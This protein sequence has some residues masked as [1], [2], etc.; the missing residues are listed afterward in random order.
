MKAVILAGGLGTRL[1]EETHLRP[2]PMVEVGGMPILWH[3]MKGFASHGINEFV[4][5][6]GYKGYI[7]K[8][9]FANYFLHTSDVEFD[10]GK[11]SF[12]L[13]HRRGEDWK[14][15]V[16][17]TG[18]HTMTG[19]RLKRVA[20]LVGD[21]TFC[22]TY[23]D[24]VSDVNIA[25]LV[26]FHKKSGRKATVTA[27]KPPGRYGAIVK[28]G[29]QVLRFEE[30]PLGDNAWINGGFFVL[31][32]AVFQYID[33]DSCVWERSPLEVL[34]SEKE[35]SSFEHMGFWK[36]MDTLRDRN[37]LEDLWAKGDAPWKTW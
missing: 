13:I 35:L 17:D 19:G 14:V 8:E 3:I 34:A 16:V 29:S 7:I 18:E 37:D 22:L 20:D 11:N 23:G 27:V 2:K 5:C 15:S 1:S 9:F 30:K 12:E 32:P 4:V 26:E 6:A 25:E 21:D 28:E 31:E 24:G 10:L 33:G 36:A